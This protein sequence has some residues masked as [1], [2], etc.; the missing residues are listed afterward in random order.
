MRHILPIYI[1]FSIL[2]AY[3]VIRLFESAGARKW[4]PGMIVLLLGWLTLSS[5]LSHPD[6]LPYFNEL[7]GNHPEK[8]LVDSDLDWG[9][10]MKRLAA[11][12]HDGGAR[13]LTLESFYW[14]NMGDRR[15]P[16]I[17]KARPD[18]PLAGWNAVALSAW[19]E[20]RFGF[21]EHEPNRKFWPDA[22]PPQEVVGKSIYLWYFPPS[23][24]LPLN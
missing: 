12:L 14:N 4:L 6:Y 15:L 24:G 1:A 13:V 23:S 7:A 20:Y 9:Q 18:T 21:E 8:I 19:K 17:R 3:G 5:I 22:L 10:D 11:R 2:A 16:V